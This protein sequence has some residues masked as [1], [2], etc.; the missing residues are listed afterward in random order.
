MSQFHNHA[1]SSVWITANSKKKKILCW[2][3]EIP[4]SYSATLSSMFSKYCNPPA[5]LSLASMQ[6]RVFL[7]DYESC[8]LTACPI[9]TYR[10]VLV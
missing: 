10:G 1:G 8:L 4:K 5:K 6:D 3:R 9:V 7:H 2:W